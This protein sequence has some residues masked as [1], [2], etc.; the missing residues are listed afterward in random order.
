MTFLYIQRYN[1]VVQLHMKKAFFQLHISVFL[2]GF[3]GILGRLI[4]LN[5][6]M[7]VW[8]RLLI[9]ALTMWVLYAILSKRLQKISW[10]DILKISGVG[11]TAAMHWVTFYGAIKYANVSVGLVCFSAVGFFTALAEPVINRTRVNWVE[12]LLGLTTIGGIYI[13]FHFDTEYKTGII[14][15]IISAFLGCLFPIFNRRFLQRINVETVLTWQITGGFITLSLLLPFYL[16]QFPAKQFFPGWEDLLWL[17]VLS[18]ICSVLAFRLT[19]NALK[20]LSAFTVNLTY[21][22]EPVYGILLAFLVYNENE[23]LSRWFYLGFAV[24]ICVLV[25]HLFLI[26]RSEKRAKPLQEK[27]AS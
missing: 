6:G 20:H 9:T 17:L 3:T 10:Q 11:F 18:W 24:I 19:A 7:M 4:T 27:T 15:G 12:L 5:E 25:I 14:L 16:Y 23:Y 26:I 8:Y 2:A 1:H 13:I 21:N 22:L